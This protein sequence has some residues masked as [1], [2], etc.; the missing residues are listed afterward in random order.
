MPGHGDTPSPGAGRGTSVLPPCPAPGEGVH[1]WIMSAAHAAKRQGLASD[2]AIRAIY[3]SISRTPK[4]REIEDGVA[5]AY[6]TTRSSVPTLIKADYNAAKASEV[7]AALPEFNE[8]D[9]VERSALDPSKTTPVTYLM[10]LFQAGEFVAVF[11]RM[12]EPEPMLW[13]YSLRYYGINENE[14]DLVTRPAPGL[15]TWFLANPVCGRAVRVPRLVKDRNP[16]GV[17]YRAEENLTAYRYIVLESDKVPPELWMRIL[18][19]LPLPI[20]S[21]VTSG[22]R[23][24][25]ALVRVDATSADEWNQIKASLGPALVTLGVDKASLSAVRLT[26]LPFCYRAD[27]SAWQKLL[28]LNPHPSNEPICSL[29]R[30]RTSPTREGNPT[31]TATP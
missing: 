21:I 7:A 22:G 11:V 12:E 4:P 25:H 9:F 14:L 26:R 16:D 10:R 23:S 24:I 13:E 2:G 15:G 29:P 18:A 17:S 28:Y 27:K 1:P 5:K 31:E 20:S 30:K 3:A 8:D 19:Q 6:G